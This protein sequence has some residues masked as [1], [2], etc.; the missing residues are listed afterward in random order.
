MNVQM[1]RYEEE[2]D[3]LE[4]RFGLRVAQALDEGID[5]PASAEV[6]ERLRFARERALA[7]AGRRRSL[8]HAVE[9][10]PVSSGGL[11]A[12]RKPGGQ[13]PGW[14]W[15]VAM[16]APLLMLVAGM[17][18]ISDIQERARIQA[19]AE[20]D[21]AL[22]ADDLPPDAYSDPGFVEFLSERRR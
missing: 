20:V 17:V 4:G 8:A 13:A 21:S 18:G 16:V 5:R 6:T 22:L 10:V 14:G 15:R 11:L 9:A 1:T 2:W 12:L 7:A 19:T 3:A